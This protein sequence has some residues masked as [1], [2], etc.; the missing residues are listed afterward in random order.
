MMGMLLQKLK[1]IR[2]GSRQPIL[3]SEE[4]MG[5]VEVILIIVVLIGLVTIFQANIKGVVA[6]IFA[7]I[8]RNASAIQ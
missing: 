3:C 2:L 1:E 7:T 5:V 8:E 4:G 6:S